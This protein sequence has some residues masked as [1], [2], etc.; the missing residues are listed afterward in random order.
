MGIIRLD[1]IPAL[2]S[3]LKGLIYSKTKATVHF[4]RFSPLARATGIHLMFTPYLK[5]HFLCR[6]FNN[7]RLVLVDVMAAVRR[8]Y[9]PAGGR[10][11]QQI[12]LHVGPCSKHF[13]FQFF[14]FN[15]RVKPGPVGCADNT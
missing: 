4:L 6:I 15:E 12:F 10:K 14:V 3:I 5:E 7:L 9:L 1:N 2:H 13:S 11:P 8:Q